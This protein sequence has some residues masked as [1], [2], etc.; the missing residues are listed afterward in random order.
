MEWTSMAS[1]LVKPGFCTISEFSRRVG[2]SQPAVSIAVSNLRL[3][4]YNGA[5]KR[6]PAD[7]SG[8]KWLRL[9]EALD[10]WD[11]SRLRLD[12]FYLER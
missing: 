7:Y 3:R 5:G 4:V 2:V 11:S 1:K 8:R 6:V 12:D 10:D 9:A